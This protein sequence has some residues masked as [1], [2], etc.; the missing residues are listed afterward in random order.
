M[1]FDIPLEHWLDLST[2]INPHAWP[3]ATLPAAVWGR[4]PE[5]GDGLESA[6][7]RY[8]GAPCPLPLAGSQAAIQS[9]PT[10]RAPCRVGVPRVGYREHAHAWCRAGHQVVELVDSDP[11]R[12]LDDGPERLDCLVVINPNNPTGRCWPIATLLDWHARLAAR[13]GWLIVDEAFMDA[14]PEASLTPFAGRPGLILLRSLG[15][16]FGLA[17]ARVGFLFAESALRAR[18]LSWLGPWTLSGPSR[19]IA[20][21][22]LADTVWQQ[23]TRAALPLAADRLAELLRRYG[24]APMGGTALFQWVLTD[25]ADRIQANLARQGILVRRF[26]R[27]PSLRFG[28]PGDERDWRR[29]E[30]ALTAVAHA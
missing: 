11:G 29:L 4:L 13:G 25:E 18:L 14:T 19:A 15:K 24:L 23:V 10:L 5:E 17:G 26:I 28:L 7:A 27:P 16:F 8:Y 12:W 22:A 9:L 3:V 30:M 21:Q 1:R 2:G 20:R 6:A